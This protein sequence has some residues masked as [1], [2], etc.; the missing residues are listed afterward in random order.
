MK[1]L[2]LILLA[3]PAFAADTRDA[4]FQKSIEEMFPKL[5]EIRRDIH[6][7]PELSN[8]EERTAKLVVDRLKELGFTDIKTGVA[9]HGVVAM[10]KGTQDGPCVAVRA[11]M[12]ALPI[13]ELRAVPYR[14]QN[15]GV[16]HACGHDVHV[17]CAL[18]VAEL[19]S[20]HRDLVKG[21]AKFLFQP[22]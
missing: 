8:E 20:K 16:M 7:H 2:S 21:S 14:S 12:D 11:D 3:I 15:P 4:I 19:L 22:A 1:R 13:K 10:L 18:G 17:T 6:M 9:K 5:V